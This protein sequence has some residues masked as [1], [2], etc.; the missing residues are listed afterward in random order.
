MSSLKILSDSQAEFI[1]GQV[2]T[3]QAGGDSFYSDSSV[4]RLSRLTRSADTHEQCRFGAPLSG[5][6]GV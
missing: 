6:R 2:G 5:D 3:V 1:D 4:Q